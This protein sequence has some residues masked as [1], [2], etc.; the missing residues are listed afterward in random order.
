MNLANIN[1]DFQYK[2]ALIFIE[3]NEVNYDM[4]NEVAN[5]MYHLE[6]LS[7]ANLI[8][9][10]YLTRAIIW[11]KSRFKIRKIN[12]LI[13]MSKYDIF[14]RVFDMRNDILDS[15]TLLTFLKNYPDCVDFMLDAFRDEEEEPALDLVLG[16][17]K[18][19]CQSKAQLTRAKRTYNR[20]LKKD[21]NNG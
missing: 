4:L 5:I 2:S 12:S 14:A 3:K 8:R 9:T 11:T 19:V 18:D 7:T 6:E 16:V 20:F 15:E 10:Y 21:G 1:N 13:K 17:F